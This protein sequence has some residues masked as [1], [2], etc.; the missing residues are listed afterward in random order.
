MKNWN[1]IKRIGCLAAGVSLLLAGCGG[2]S[3]SAGD[4]SAASSSGSTEDTY[5][6]SLTMHDPVTSSIGLIY[7]DWADQVEEATDGH[8][9]VELYGSGTLAAGTDVVDYVKSGA[10]DIGWIY[11]AFFSGQFPL[12]EVVS[13]PMLG[14]YHP[15]QT[16]NV[17]W[18]LYED[19]DALQDELSGFKVL[20]LYG[21]PVNFISTKSVEVTTA[22]DLKGLNL[23]CP[24][25]G[26]A[27]V[28]QDMGVNTILM[29]SNDIY[30]GLEKGT[31]AG[32]VHE[33]NG[34]ATFS[35]DEQLN[36]YMDLPLYEGVFILGMN[37]DSWN[38]LPE[39]YQTAIE[40]VSL[41]TGSISVAEQF[42]DAAMEHKDEILAAGGTLV[43][44]SDQLTEALQAAADSY[45]QEWAAANTT[46]DFDAEA[47]YEEAAQLA[48][49]YATY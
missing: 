25:G 42:N 44:P 13:I 31:I 2:G 10:A 33:W 11:T 21:N 1:R 24:S 49:T 27:E 47:Y 48:D 19:N 15:A 3:A 40:S 4:S 29:N 35:L 37:W 16:A 41:R 46:D 39:E 26:V 6:L 14:L 7:Q 20:M 43:E 38:Q 5:T 30:D 23:R 12:T 28:L 9:K 45:A 17:L 8:V 34:I 32:T 22:D 36:Y 18:D